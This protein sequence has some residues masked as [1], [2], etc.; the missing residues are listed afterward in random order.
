MDMGGNS[1]VT[2][3]CC[4]LIPY[5]HGDGEEAKNWGYSQLQNEENTQKKRQDASF[6]L[7]NNSTMEMLQLRYM[8]L[9]NGVES[10]HIYCWAPILQC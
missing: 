5:I 7:T 10:P 3:L 6:S 9:S 2:V 8:I 4:T 1:V